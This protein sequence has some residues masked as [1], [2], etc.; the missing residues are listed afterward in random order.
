MISIRN[1]RGIII[2]DCVLIKRIKREY[3]E[4]FYVIKINN[5]DEI[6]QFPEKLKVPKLTQE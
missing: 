6:N 2:T 5:V 4:S 3:Y 1:E